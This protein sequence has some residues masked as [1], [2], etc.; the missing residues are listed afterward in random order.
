[1]VLNPMSFSKQVMTVLLKMCA[2]AAI[3]GKICQN[4]IIETFF[5]LVGFFYEYAI[6]ADKKGEEGFTHICSS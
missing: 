6:E 1:M 2:I 5:Q 4:T 3:C